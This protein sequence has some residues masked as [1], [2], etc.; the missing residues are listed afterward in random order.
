MREPLPPVA[1]VIGFIDRVNRG[2]ADALGQLMTEDHAL[3]VF[4]EQPLVGRAENVEAWRG[5]CAA[6]PAYVIHPHVIADH[7]GTVAVLGHTTGSHLGLPE[8]EE[9]QHTLIWVAEVIEGALRSWTLVEDDPPNRRL[10]G[11]ERPGS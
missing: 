1:V 2:D 7:D 3:R 6:Y 10:L 9:R 11:L 5:Y 4:D 8:A